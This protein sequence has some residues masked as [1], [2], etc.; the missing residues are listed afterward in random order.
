MTAPPTPDELK[1]RLLQ[2]IRPLAE[3]LIPD[4][5]VEG[6][7]WVG[8][9]RSDGAKWGVVI[10]GGKA[11]YY[12]NFGTG[13]GGTSALALIRDAVCDGDPRKAYAWALGFLGDAVLLPPSPAPA[14]EPAAEPQPADVRKLF[15]AAQPFSW[16]GPAGRYL[17]GRSI[18]PDK[19]PPY[20]GGLR[21]QPRCWNAEVR[22]HLPAMLA[23]VIGANGSGFYALHRTYLQDGPGGW[24][25][26]SVA[27]PKKVLG[28][29][30][31]GLIPLVRGAS[32][33]PIARAPRGD[34]VVIGEGIENVLT[35]AR[36]YPERRAVAA[37]AI[38]NLP[39]LKLP[40]AI[41]SVMLIRDRDGENQAVQ[42]TRD[43]AIVRWKTEGR[44][45]E[46]WEP[47]EGCKDANDYW[48][49]VCAGKREA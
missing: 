27:K 24:R 49:E 34:A 4:G 31:G 47:P 36:F 5:K 23:S 14:S 38:A 17:I 1:H 44:F 20:F 18:T 12:Q 32:G 40:R 46:V 42:D 7:E 11:G 45:V 28:K 2:R 26:A 25:K 19:L 48:R 43:R 3:A 8:H 39:N 33:K 37:V 15:A 30:T 29:F 21:F 41:T 22:E 16:D 10:K 6:H 9:S 13:T 35:V